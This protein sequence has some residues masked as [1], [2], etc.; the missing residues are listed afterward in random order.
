MA[1]RSADFIFDNNNANPAPYIFP[2]GSLIVLA[3]GMN[4]YYADHWRG[5]YQRIYQLPLGA[6]NANRTDREKF[7]YGGAGCPGNTSCKL[8][9]EDPFIYFD[10]SAG[11]W[12]VLLHQ[13]TT[14]ISATGELTSGGANN[15]SL[16]GGYARSAGPSLFGDWIYD[17]GRPAYGGTVEYADGTVG[18]L[19][20]RER[21]KIFFD[22]TG[23]PVLLTNG[24]RF[25]PNPNGS[26]VF[27]FGQPIDGWW[28]D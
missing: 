8:W 7:C 4:V 27:T 16:V 12:R 23:R 26:N 2:N 28:D 18:S 6:M 5:P 13:Y 24:V 21:P 19:G 22:D 10:S 20:G 11:F 9:I 1:A 3:C 15:L 14:C 17:F 25:N